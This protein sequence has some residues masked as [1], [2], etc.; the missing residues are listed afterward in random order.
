MKGQDHCE[1]TD[2]PVA[3]SVDVI[4]DR[5]TLL[6]IRELLLNN[7]HEYNEFLA[8]DEKIS[9]N[10]LA[11]R[12][13]KLHASGIIK[14][15]RHPTMK[16]RKIYYLTE[17]GKELIYV[18]VP[19]ILWSAKHLKNVVRVPK[20]QKKYLDNPQQLIEGVLYQL[21]LWEKDNLPVRA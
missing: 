7:R 10:I 9:T 13:K 2:C 20:T 4:G 14:F 19:M 8:M 17:A 15:F 1:R 16:A 6:V 3:C 12:L 18:M 11:D 5:W 21:Q